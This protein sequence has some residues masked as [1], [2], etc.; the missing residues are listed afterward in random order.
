MIMIWGAFLCSFIGTVHAETF[1]QMTQGLNPGLHRTWQIH[2]YQRI[3]GTGYYNLDL[4]RG[5]TSSG[6]PIFP[7]PISGG[8]WLSSSDMR[9][10]ADVSGVSERGSVAINLRFDVLDNVRLG[11]MPNGTAIDS[12]SQ[13]A[14]ED[15]IVVRQA[16]ATALTPLG[17]V[18][19]GRMS[20]QWGLGMLVNDGTC[21]DC[22]TVDVSDR[23]G[24]ITALAGHLWALSY[25]YAA[26]GQG[27]DRAYNVPQI[28]A[29]PSDDAH[30]FSVAVMDVLSDF[31]RSRRQRAGRTSVEYGA[32]YATRRQDYDNPYTYLHDAETVPDTTLMSRDY[33]ARAT[34]GWIRVT[35]PKWKI[36]LE[37]AYLT[38]NVGNVSLLPGVYSGAELTS[39]QWGVA[40]ETQHQPTDKLKWGIDAGAASGDDAP[41][42]GGRATSDFSAAEMGDLDGAQFAFPQDA[43][44]DNFR[45]H[46]DYRVDRILWREIVGTVTDAVY[47]RPHLSWEIAQA[48]PGVLTFHQA[49]VYSQAMQA[50]STLSGSKGLGIEWDPSLEYISTD[51][52]GFQLDY[53][54][55]MPLGGFDNL[56][57][58]QEASPAHLFRTHLRYR[59]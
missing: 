57:T 50:T 48:G 6:R 3:R 26:V 52:M 34:D 58:G 41:G 13:L 46:A 2:G 49:L 20:T 27:I 36:G 59:F 9:F 30:S 43:T 25:D 12:T 39:Q 32:Y 47:V 55:L 8:Q 1:D 23:L 11:S 44:V 17:F 42:L 35:A 21:I 54:L 16:Y 24:F 18:V 37:T 14:P 29:D 28:D 33:R 22:N 53:A 51:G 45:F 56:V 31:S 4:D 5:L 40:L 15:S 38:A 7:V 19:A 10:R